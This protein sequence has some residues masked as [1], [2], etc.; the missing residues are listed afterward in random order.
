MASQRQAGRS[1]DVHRIASGARR[2]FGKGYWTVTVLKSKGVHV[3]NGPT[4]EF[5]HNSGL[6]RKKTGLYSGPTQWCLTEK[7]HR[8]TRRS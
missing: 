1:D 7:G 2:F 5:M 8:Y 4:V 6:I 3:R